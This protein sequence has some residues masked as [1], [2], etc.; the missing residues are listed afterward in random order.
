MNDIRP[1][2]LLSNDD[3][4]QAKGLNELMDMLSP[5]GDILVM[6]PDSARSGSAC[7]ITE[8]DPLRYRVVA[9]RPGMKV[10]ACDGTPADCVKLALEAEAARRP[11][12][13]VGGINHGDNSSVNAHYSGTMGV[14][15][16]GC[17][18]GIPSVGFSL[19]DTRADADFSPAAPYVRAILERVL[20]TGL[21]A[22]VCL[23]VNFPKPSAR[24]YRG[25]RICRMARGMWTKELHAAEHP[26][27]G[28]YFWLTGEYVD[29]EPEREDT[30]AWA[31][32]HGYVAVT[33]VTVDVTAYQAMDGLKDL[34]AL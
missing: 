25:T 21:P 26:R 30:D 3:G 6:A 22:G 7:A 10:C 28:R 23:N 5:L 31:L 19:C 17:M 13:V 34:E 32:A 24:G 18:K 2:V 33:P 1:L 15:M 8:H 12:V 14:V 9:V 11:D 27:G 16:E 20:R 29:K 4:I